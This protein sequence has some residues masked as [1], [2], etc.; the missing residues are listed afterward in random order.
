MVPPH[1]FNAR[2]SAL[3]LVGLREAWPAIAARGTSRSPKYPLPDRRGR[4]R[5]TP[6]GTP[7]AAKLRRTA[8]PLVQIHINTY[9]HIRICAYR[10]TRQ[11]GTL[12]RRSKGARVEVRAGETFATASVSAKKAGRQS[13]VLC[14][15]FQH[16]RVMLCLSFCTVKVVVWVVQAAA[17]V[18]ASNRFHYME[19]PRHE[20]SQVWSAAGVFDFIHVERERESEERTVADEFFFVS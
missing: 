18:V 6:Q 20:R 2:T 5:S 15:L 3:R 12:A 4:G 7:P 19:V 8:A 14:V 1:G 10:D 13:A 16:S 17:R 11:S 9:T